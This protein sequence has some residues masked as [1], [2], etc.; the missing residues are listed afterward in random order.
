[1]MVHHNDGGTHAEVIAI[2]LDM[3]TVFL[4][5]APHVTHGTFHGLFS[6]GVE[7]GQSLRWEESCATDSTTTREQ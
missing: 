2:A 3:R 5:N 6:L 7:I 1:M 4:D